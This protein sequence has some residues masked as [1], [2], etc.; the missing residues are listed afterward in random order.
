[1]DL[2]TLKAI[3]YACGTASCFAGLILYG[4]EVKTDGSIIS[5]GILIVVG[6]ILLLAS[7]TE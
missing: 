6:V 3:F 2:M 5:G 1:M 7:Y 4:N